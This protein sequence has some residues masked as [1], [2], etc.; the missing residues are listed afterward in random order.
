MTVEELINK[1]YKYPPN[2]EVVGFDPDWDQYH[3]LN[4]SQPRF[5]LERGLERS[6]SPRRK[7]GFQVLCWNC[8][9]GRAFN[10]GI[11]PHVENTEL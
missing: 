11:C 5:I 10:N 4:C 3:G 6:I 1:L 9:C 2:Y 8:N 7:A